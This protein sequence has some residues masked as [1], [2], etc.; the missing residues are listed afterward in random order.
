MWK[1]VYG[2]QFYQ[3]NILLSLSSIKYTNKVYCSV[4]PLPPASAAHLWV[5]MLFMGGGI[6][7]NKAFP[8]SSGLGLERFH[9]GVC[10]ITRREKRGRPFLLHEPSTSKL[11]CNMNVRNSDARSRERSCT[12]NPHVDVAGAW[13]Q[14]LET[15]GSFSSTLT[16]YSSG[17]QHTAGVSST[18]T[19]YVPGTFTGK[20]ACFLMYYWPTAREAS[21]TGTCACEN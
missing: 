10:G 6:L 5:L 14:H 18:W 3:I 21:L 16:I 1:T 4:L 12:R 13:K 20:L 2:F 9:W 8:R 11:T 19:E 15:Q 17:Y 7:L